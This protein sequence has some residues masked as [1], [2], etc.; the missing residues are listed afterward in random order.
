MVVVKTHTSL[1]TD[2]LFGEGSLEV[3]VHGEVVYLHA[4]GV[5]GVDVH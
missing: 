3:E 5:V 2:D 1:R 4:L